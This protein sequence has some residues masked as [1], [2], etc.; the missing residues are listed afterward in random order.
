MKYKVRTTA[1]GFG[2][3]LRTQIKRR[4]RST[5]N[6][7]REQARNTNED[8]F[9][10]TYNKSQEMKKWRGITAARKTIAGTKTDLTEATTLVVFTNA[11]S[12]TKDHAKHYDSYITGLTPWIT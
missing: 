10:R 12:I 2:T 6:S 9:S 7:S 11:N 5:T 1:M 8:K 4:L 3:L